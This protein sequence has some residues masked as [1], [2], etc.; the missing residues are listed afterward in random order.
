LRGVDWNAFDDLIRHSATTHPPQHPYLRST[1]ISADETTDHH[2]QRS[3]M[4]A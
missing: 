3:P 2:P 4:R 1:L